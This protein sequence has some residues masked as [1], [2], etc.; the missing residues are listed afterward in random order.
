[1]IKPYFFAC[2]LLL[3]FYSAFAQLTSLDSAAIAPQTLYFTIEQGGLVGPGADRIQQEIQDNQFFLLGEYHGSHQLSLLTKQLLYPMKLAG[4]RAFALEVGPVT[5]EKLDELSAD[6]QTTKERLQA[7][8]EQYT[9]YDETREYAAEPAPFFDRPADWDFLA[10]AT[11]Y[12]F[13][14]WGLDQ[15]YY[16][17]MGF[18]FD[19]I[20]ATKGSYKVD[21]AK[22]EAD[23][24][25]AKFFLQQELKKELN[26]EAGYSLMSRLLASDSIR[27]FFAHFPSHRPAQK[28]IQALQTSWK[29]YQHNETGQW[30][31]NNNLRA[32]YMK[33]NFYRQY[34]QG[35]NKYRTL[36]NV[37]VKMGGMHLG[38]GASPMEVYDLGNMITE[39]AD[40]NQT[41]SV[42]ILCMNRYYQTDKQLEDEIGGGR[43]SAFYPILVQAKKDQ[44][45]LIE[46][47]P[48]LKTVFYMGKTRHQTNPEME[49]LIKSFDYV[50]IPPVD[51]E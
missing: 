15:E 5:A 10:E 19:D 33:Q 35:L 44:W 38:R 50:L 49:H 20:M 8:Y 3:T 43:E 41:A 36:P 17:S 28:I 40:M 39:L 26:T 11:I 14:L 47:R 1:M 21:S 34:I 12:D 45:T 24:A 32:K 25:K 46:L 4:Y 37:F 13:D 22:L 29:L 31:E 7:F 48:F 18:L 51:G 23:F 16:Y 6:P 42:H 2:T 30:Y 27:T 9:L